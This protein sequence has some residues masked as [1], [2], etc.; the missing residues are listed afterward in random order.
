L[1]VRAWH[2]GAAAALLAAQG[3]P[4][5]TD[6]PDDDLR[7][8]DIAN[9]A[10]AETPASRPSPW[11][12]FVE[13]A[14]AT[15][16]GPD[17]RCGGVNKR[18]SINVGYDG[19]V[20]PGLRAVFESRLDLNSRAQLGFEK[21]THTLKE[22][23]LAWTA[24]PQW[25]VEGGRIN[26]R[27]GVAT[28]YNPTDF[29]RARSLRTM[30]SVDPAATKANRL[31]TVVLR[32][33]RV[34]DTGAASV[35]FAP[36]L[37]EHRSDA[38][39]SADLGATNDR[40]RWLFT[41]T[42][43]VGAGFAPQW[44]YYQE[45]SGAP[46]FGLNLSWAPH[47]AVVSYLEWRGGRAPDQLD[48]FSGVDRGASFRSQATVGA[49]LNPAPDLTLIA[50]YQYNGAAPDSRRW[51]DAAHANPRAMR[52]YLAWSRDLQ[53]LPTR[54]AL[55][56]MARWKNA[57]VRN[58]D[59]SALAR[60]NLDDDS[61]MGWL[62]LLYRW[63]STDLGLQWQANHGGRHSEFGVVPPDEAWQVLLR[64]HF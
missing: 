63:G 6:A 8:L 26:V 4:A 38:P 55:F 31:G 52:A 64:H 25:T 45:E 11:R 2:I 58:V 43:N 42:Q 27:H 29:F 21:R 5:Q 47:D 20:A 34:W 44:L 35:L 23:Y 3:A 19:A 10:S 16:C 22:A 49:T 9:Q 61:R 39:F 15:S 12:G 59:I 48:A 28:G 7:A 18:L 1:T 51:H 56:A 54:R 37:K 14:A 24:D 17:A 30:V 50:E 62:E 57:V 60:L 33:Q 46:Q 36:K 13:A 40:H 53:E 41:W 32:S